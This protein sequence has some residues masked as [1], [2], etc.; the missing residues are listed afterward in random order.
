MS[1]FFAI[2]QCSLN[3]FLMLR[4]HDFFS[5]ITRTRGI[6]AHASRRSSF[7]FQISYVSSKRIFFPAIKPS[8]SQRL[9]L[10]MLLVLFPEFSP[11]YIFFVS[12]L[13][14]CIAFSLVTVFRNHSV[15]W[16]MPQVG[17]GQVRSV[18]QTQQEFFY[19]YKQRKQKVGAFTA[20][21]T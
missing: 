9:K 8:C 4:Y 13:S 14:Q 7:L 17:S 19:D 11:S 18:N 16:E 20:H 3:D 10:F 6:F 2:Q 5:S 1:T 21:S 15:A 12:L